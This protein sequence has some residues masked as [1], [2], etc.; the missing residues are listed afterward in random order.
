MPN[1]RNDRFGGRIEAARARP[2]SDPK[3]DRRDD[4]SR[5]DEGENEEETPVGAAHRMMGTAAE[6]SGRVVRSY[7]A[8]S[9]LT[10]FGIGFGLGLVVT[11]LLRPGRHESSSWSDSSVAETLRGLSR[12]LMQVPQ[13][14]AES[15]MSAFGRR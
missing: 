6:A 13:A 4:A 12:S 8:A 5:E 7:P 11:T 14:T 10:S 1:K 2:E 3:A 15:M 9:M